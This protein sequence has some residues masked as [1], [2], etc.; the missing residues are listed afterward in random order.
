M[1][2][3]TTA[4][5]DILPISEVIRSKGAMLCFIPDGAVDTKHIYLQCMQAISGTSKCHMWKMY[6]G[7][8]YQWNLLKYS[9]KQPF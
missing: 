9:A 4:V 2:E 7:L 5:F 1:Y 6:S 3:P 8:I